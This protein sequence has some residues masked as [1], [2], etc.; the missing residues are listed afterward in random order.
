MGFVRILVDGEPHRL[1]ELGPDIRLD[2]DG[3]LIAVDR[4][5][6][7]HADKIAAD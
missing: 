2:R 6:R 3:V 5:K 4:I 7:R 1:L